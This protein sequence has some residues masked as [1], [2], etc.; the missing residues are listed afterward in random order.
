MGLAPRPTPASN[1]MAI[2]E[3]T[4]ASSSTAMQNVR[5]SAPCPPYSSGNGRPNSPM[6]PI[7]FTMSSGSSSTRSIS[8]A[9]GAMT[10]SANSRT[11]RRNSCCSAVRS[12]SMEQR[13]AASF[14]CCGYRIVRRHPLAP[15]RVVD[16][17]S[18]FGDDEFR[19]EA[20]V[21]GLLAV[22]VLG[23]T[24]VPLGQPLQREIGEPHPGRNDLGRSAHR[25]VEAPD[26]KRVGGSPDPQVHVER[27]FVLGNLLSTREPAPCSVRLQSQRWLSGGQE[28]PEYEGSLDVD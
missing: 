20:A 28:V 3:S 21:Q 1:V 11:A 5:K 27:A 23:E 16:D 24:R 14:R 2:E 8:S 15:S 18:E 19:R 6:V 10:S 7:C 26:G 13:L 9:R 22:A 25:Q 17:Q 12:K 4:R